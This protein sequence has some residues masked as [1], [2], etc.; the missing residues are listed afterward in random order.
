MGLFDFLKPKKNVRPEREDEDGH[1]IDFDL[2]GDSSDARD[3]SCDC[4]DCG[5]GDSDS[6]DSSS[7]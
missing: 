5:C 1:S 2:T 4:G 7:D 6:G 3:D